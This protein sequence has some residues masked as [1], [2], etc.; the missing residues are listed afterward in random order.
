M[1]APTNPNLQQ[2]PNQLAALVIHRPPPVG[3]IALLRQAETSVAVA[4]DAEGGP[5]IVP[6]E[7]AREGMQRLDDVQAL[8]NQ[9]LPQAQAGSPPEDGGF[10]EACRLTF[11]RAG[12]YLRAAF[13]G[14]LEGVAPYWVVQ[15]RH[16]HC[17]GTTIEGQYVKPACPFR[18]EVVNDGCGGGGLV[19]CKPCAC[20]EWE[21]AV[22]S[23][24]DPARWWESKLAYGKLRCPKRIFP[25]HSGGGAVELRVGGLA[26]TRPLWGGRVY[27]AWRLIRTL[28]GGVLALFKRKAGG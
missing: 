13:A 23:I 19:Y 25:E 8:V 28:P 12:E 11:E 27:M 7:E 4:L 10:F 18:T 22:I 9:R 21:G 1:P 15:F 14:V 3:R 17:H 24:A 20:G 6:L 2:S 26:V 5:R 16:I